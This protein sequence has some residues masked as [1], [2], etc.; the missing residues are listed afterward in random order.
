MTW[1]QR[2]FAPKTNAAP[3][4]V[5]A[6]YYGGLTSQ[7]L[8]AYNQAR[9]LGPQE[10]VCHAPF[11]NLYFGWGGQ[12]IACCYNRSHVMGTY[13]Q[14]SIKEIWFGEKANDLRRHLEQND[15]SLGCNGC[16]QQ[17]MAGNFDATKAKQY[18]IFP[19]NANRFPSVMEFELSN[20]CNL[21][22]EMCSGD[23]SSLIR[24]NR[25]K[26]PPMP[27]PYD[28]A[29]VAQLEEFIP[30][31]TEVKFYGGEPFLIEIYYKIWEKIMVINP[32]IRISVQTNATV[33]NNRVK[34]ILSKSHFHLNISFDSLQKEP[35]E[36]IR[37]NAKFERV[38]ENM[39]WFREYTRERGTFFGISACMM[40][41]N[42]R[43]APDFVKFCNDWEC[44][45]YF[46]TVFFPPN[47]SIHNLPLETLME[48][49]DYW[50][51]FDFPAENPIQTK[52]RLHFM[53][54]VKQ[55]NFWIENAD[56]RTTAP[57]QIDSVMELHPL[58]AKR[59]AE[60]EGDTGGQAR[61]DAIQEKL[62]QMNDALKDNPGL[63]QRMGKFVYEDDN[64]IDNVIFNIE[65][66][67][68]PELIDMMAA[69]PVE[70]EQAHD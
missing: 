51:G 26:R 7:T 70:T 59:I 57:K 45:V 46:H 21:E 68:V 32:E 67:S 19:S 34:T 58:L 66:R 13:P 44:S 37:I 50:S 25:E 17:I 43:E 47:C 12:A 41:Q 38:M 9:P 23:F 36:A 4:P 39:Q 1:F 49:R 35:Y 31:L 16:L 63:L 42:W 60:K 53:N 33:L 18:D 11:K 61:L 56:K 55:V 5:E 6:I 40:R 65:N 69:L 22:C 30:Y 27:N 14:Q 8:A 3:A 10:K 62:V 24:E 2:L 29:F 64:F 52:N 28:D 15:F 20:V 54:L 48:I